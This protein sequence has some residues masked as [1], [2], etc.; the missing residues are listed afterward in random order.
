MTSYTCDKCGKKGNIIVWSSDVI[1]FLDFNL[2]E[3][4]SRKLEKWVMENEVKEGTK[5]R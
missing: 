3:S 5:K 2:C 4:C 1:K